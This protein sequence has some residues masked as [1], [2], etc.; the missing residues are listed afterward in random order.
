MCHVTR[1]VA[2][3]SSAPGN[4]SII[5]QPR[6]ASDKQYISAVTI[7]RAGNG[8]ADPPKAKSRASIRRISD[9]P[10][11]LRILPTERGLSNPHTGRIR[12]SDVFFAA[13]KPFLLMSH[14]FPW[15][16]LEAPGLASIRGRL[17]QPLAATRRWSALS[18]HRWHCRSHPPTSP[19][20][21]TRRSTMEVPERHACPKI[22]RAVL[23]RAAYLP[24]AATSGNRCVT[25]AR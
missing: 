2:C 18:A 9:V 7:F 4:N 1:L 14:R 11:T 3:V 22:A 6:R 17:A 23:I 20:G 15:G 8:A 21:A 13:R 24:D 25:F 5:A 12:N 19:Q 16:P 10:V